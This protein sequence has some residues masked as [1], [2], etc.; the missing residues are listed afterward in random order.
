MDNPF[1]DLTV[2][3]AYGDHRAVV[4]WRVKEDYEGGIFFIYRSD[5]G[6][7]PWTLLTPNGVT[8]EEYSDQALNPSNRTDIPHYRILLEV[9][10]HSYD[11]PVVGIYNDLKRREYGGVRRIQQLEYKRMQVADGI[12]VFLYKPLKTGMPCPGSQA[13]TGQITAEGCR[14][15]TAGGDS[16]DCYG[17]PWVGGYSPPFQ[18]LVEILKHGPV[19]VDYNAKIGSATQDQVSLFRLLG[20]PVARKGDL[21]VDPKTDRRWFIENIDP[22]LFKGSVAVAQHASVYLIDRKADAYRIP[23]PPLQPYR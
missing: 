5:N 19:T 12:P 23:V 11:S 13:D 4:K 15:E 18:T 8:G 3:P 7:P 16:M 6:T 20:F 14:V 1:L 21:I 10:G 17:T 2:Y 22:F 9:D